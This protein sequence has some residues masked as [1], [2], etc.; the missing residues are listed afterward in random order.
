[1]SNRFSEIVPVSEWGG[2]ILREGEVEWEKN[3]GEDH[4]EAE[5]R[6]ERDEIFQFG[7]LVE[8]EYSVVLEAPSRHC[9]HRR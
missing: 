1:M 6:Y 7:G 5:G 9:L 2:Q 8:G 4:M 3:E